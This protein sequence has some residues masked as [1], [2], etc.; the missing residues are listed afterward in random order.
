MTL[1]DVKPAFS[2]DIERGPTI[3]FSLG[4]PSFYIALQLFE[5][6]ESNST[7]KCTTRSGER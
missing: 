4:N 3:A 7:A 5:G 2:R 6:G 1:A